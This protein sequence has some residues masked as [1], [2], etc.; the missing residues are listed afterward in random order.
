MTTP[1]QTPAGIAYDRAG[2][3]ND[4][5]VVLLHAGVTD[6]R[7]WDLQWEALTAAHDAVRLDLRGFGDSTRRPDGALSP[8]DDVLDTLAA[9]D[10]ERCRMVGASLGASVAVE[11]TLIRPDKVSSLFLSAPGG[12]LIAES[13]PD[14]REFIDAERA[15]LIQRDLDAAVETNLAWWIDGPHRNADAVDPTVR[16]AV[17]RMQRRALE[18]V[19]DWNDV[20]VKEFSPPSHSRLGEV[21]V[22]TLVLVGALDLDAIL[23]T[24]QR[25]TDK[26]SNS[27]QVEVPGAAH[28]PSMERAEDFTALLLDWLASADPT[29]SAEAHLP[30]RPRGDPG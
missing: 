25:V 10:I 13:T 18:L 22:P 21:L 3:R 5:P 15:A 8:V 27:R 4:L 7:M 19:A 20:E 26:V 2:P 23:R 6:R 11:A 30:D 1:S 14:L 17:S 24:A 28:L 9:L 12:S 29:M 16:D